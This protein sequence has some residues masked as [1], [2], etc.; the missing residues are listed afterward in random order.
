MTRTQK[1]LLAIAALV[2]GAIVVY[3]DT[4][5]QKK[6]Q[7]VTVPNVAQAIATRLVAAKKPK[8]A[9]LVTDACKASGCECAIV[10]GRNGL[11][12]DAFSRAK[13]DATVNELKEERGL[14]AELLPK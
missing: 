10:A 12:I 1:V 7:S 8:K 4:R 14:V 5:V 11:D 13:I 6:T 2:L 9:A 3:V